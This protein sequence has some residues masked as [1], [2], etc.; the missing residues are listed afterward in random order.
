LGDNTRLDDGG[1]VRGDLRS[2]V[3]GTLN[4]RVCEGLLDTC[5]GAVAAVL[6]VVRQV[7]NNPSQSRTLWP[8]Q[9]DDRFRTIIRHTGPLRA[10][11][12]SS[13][14][15]RHYRIFRQLD[16]PPLTVPSTDGLRGEGQCL[17]ENLRSEILHP[18]EL[19]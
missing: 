1:C 3:A 11:S 6:S 8:H 16:P 15:L 4:V 14:K 2:S 17:K 13:F 7:S 10:F 9:N 18:D 5:R 12:M 19:G